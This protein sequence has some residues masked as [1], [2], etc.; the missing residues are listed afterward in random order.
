MD[1]PPSV[2]APRQVESQEA[3]EALFAAIDVDGSGAIDA[4]ELLAAVAK[5]FRWI[6]CSGDQVFRYSGI[7]VNRYS[8]NQVFRWI[9]YSGGSG[10]QVNRYSGNQVFR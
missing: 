9:R 5:V 4:D 7:Q 6:R 2:F 10:V 3:C 8:G 1:P